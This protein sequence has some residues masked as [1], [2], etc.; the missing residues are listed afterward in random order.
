MRHMT[1][2]EA[3]ADTK[4]EGSILLDGRGEKIMY[5]T[6][7]EGST[8]VTFH[9][10]D[11]AFLDKLANEAERLT[12]EFIGDVPPLEPLGDDCPNCKADDCECVP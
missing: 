12:R 2:A 11:T 3:E 7:G 9:V 6:F 4:I 8:R 1:Y 5:M 10:N